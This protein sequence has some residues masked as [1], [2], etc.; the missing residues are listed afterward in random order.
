[1]TCHTYCERLMKKTT[2]FLRVFD[3]TALT[4][5]GEILINPINSYGGVA[6]IKYKKDVKVVVYDNKIYITC[7]TGY[8][9]D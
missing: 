6:K 7:G 3:T 2:N 4:T 8:N 1:M 9:I 5:D